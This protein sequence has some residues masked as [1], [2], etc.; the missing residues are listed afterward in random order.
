MRGGGLEDDVAETRESR[1]WW[2]KFEVVVQTLSALG[3]IAIPI[4]LFVVG[5]RITERQ[6]QD[7]ETQLQADRVERML[8]H[9]ASTS[10]DERKLAISVL[11][12]FSNEHE[13]PA[14]LV[15]VLV[16]VASTDP[17]KD[18]AATASAALEKVAQTG[19]DVSPA[20]QKGLSALPYR[21]DVHAPPED[22]KAAA[23]T[24]S[25]AGGDVVIA[26]QQ[27]TGAQP[28]SS[29]LRY[30]RPEDAAQAQQIA[31]RLSKQGITAEVKDFSSAVGQGPVRPKSFDLVV[32]K[33]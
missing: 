20:A 3:A 13:F 19:S 2:D 27:Q 14:E 11:Q 16:A 8:G 4:A 22:P 26:D 12:Y 23:A 17:R 25:L 15:P 7:T 10:G 6:R 1:D 31:G 32:G 5:N 18:V 30:Y 21:V 33:Q 24:A 28:A 29:E 9:L